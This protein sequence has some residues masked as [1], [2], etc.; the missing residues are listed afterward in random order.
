MNTSIKKKLYGF[1]FFVVFIL[2]CFWIYNSFLKP[3][4]SCSD[5]IQNQNETGV[6]CGGTCTSCEVLSLKDIRV[7]R[8]PKIFST[9]DGKSLVLFAEVLNPNEGYRAQKFSYDFLL[10]DTAGNVIETVTGEESI[11]ALERKLLVETNVHSYRKS[12][13]RVSLMVKNPA[14]VKSFDPAHN[15]LT[16]SEGPETDIANGQIR[17]RGKIRNEGNNSLSNIR[18]VSILRDSRSGELFA[19]QTFLTEV[20]AFEERSFIVFFPSDDTIAKTLDPDNTQVFVQA[21]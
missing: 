20:Q 2:L 16:V 13:A 18:I 21:E 11:G 9:N 8:E 12:V 17:V 6:D 7:A 14:W 10:Y 4:P 1:G 3:A 19:A 5:G 15:P